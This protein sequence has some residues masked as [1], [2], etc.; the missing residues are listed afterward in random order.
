VIV[1]GVGRD[2]PRL[3]ALD[4]PDY[5]CENLHRA[6]PR[7]ALDSL[8]RFDGLDRGVGPMTANVLCPQDIHPACQVSVTVLRGRQPIATAAGRVSTGD[9]LTG[10]HLRL[11]FTPR[12]RRVLR[13]AH[14][15]AVPVR[16]RV[17]THPVHGRARSIVTDELLDDRD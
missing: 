6:A 2:H 8:E 13:R 7:S 16:V 10:R 1:C 17:T 14:R 3:D 15:T 4:Q 5:T 12:G 11:D 9:V